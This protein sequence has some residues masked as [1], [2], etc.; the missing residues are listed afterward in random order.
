M[1]PES[2]GPSTR[3]QR[4]VIDHWT[5]DWVKSNH[6]G[7]SATTKR[8]PAPERPNDGHVISIADL[9]KTFGPTIALDG[10]DLQVERGEV[11]GFLGPNG[12]GKTVRIRILLGRSEP[13]VVRRRCSVATRGATRSR[14]TGGLPT[15]RATSACGRASRAAR[16]ST[17]CSGCPAGSTASAATHSSIGSNSIL[18]MALLAM[19]LTVSSVLRLRKEEV[20]FRSDL[21][22]ATPTSRSTWWSGHLAVTSVGTA[23]ALVTMGTTTGIGFAS[24]TGDEARIAQLAM[25]ALLMVPAHLVV[26]GIAFCLVASWPRQALLAWSVVAVIV[27][28]DMFGG[29]LDLPQW[30]LNMS[31]FQHVPAVPA[32]PVVALPIVILLICSAVLVAAGSIGMRRRDIG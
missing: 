17:S 30:A 26:A 2:F 25:A 4:P 28:I 3:D 10:L 11:H 23:V 15:S 22:M 7:C 12:A 1:R 20:A 19:G 6:E 16:S 31:P 18:M 29:L 24:M 27:V 21:V 14:C 5:P 9:V 8:P 32:V 13:T